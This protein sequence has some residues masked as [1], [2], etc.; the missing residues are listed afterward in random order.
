MSAVSVFAMDKSK[1]AARIDNVYFLD[2]I[3]ATLRWATEDI[4]RAE[5]PANIRHLLARLDRLEAKCTLR[6]SVFGSQLPRAQ[7]LPLDCG[8]QA[9]GRHLRN[10]VLHG[11]PLSLRR[12][13]E[14]T[15]PTDDGKGEGVRFRSAKAK[16]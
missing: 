16:R 7:R 9:W 8:A 6:R 10:G 1:Y 5:L 11:R 12:G 3:G 2:R 4:A 15:A 14:F 13:V